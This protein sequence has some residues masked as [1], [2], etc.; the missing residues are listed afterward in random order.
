MTGRLAESL[1]KKFALIP[2]SRKLLLL[3]APACAC[4]VPYLKCAKFV[5]LEDRDLT[6]A[7]APQACSESA[8]KVF[9][10]SIVPGTFAHSRPVPA[11]ALPRT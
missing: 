7:S 6:L 10:V 8:E 1:Q 3:W 2:N 5:T 9:A 11:H 4:A